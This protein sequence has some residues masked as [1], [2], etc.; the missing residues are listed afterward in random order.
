MLTQDEYAEIAEQFRNGCVFC[1]P[2]Q[3]L[4]VA[5]SERFAVC[6]DAAPLVPGHLILHST[7]HLSCAGEVPE[8]WYEELDEIRTAVRTELERHY[9]AVVSYEHGRAGHC[10]SDGPEHR[11]CHHFHLHF[12]PADLDVTVDLHRRFK[13]VP[14]A[15]YREIPR[16]YEDFGDYLFFETVSGEMS[17]FPVDTE[18]ERH[19]MRT[20]IS[21]A[22]KTPERADWRAYRNADLLIASMRQLAVHKLDARQ[23]PEAVRRMS[24]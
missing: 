5:R 21:R 16:L 12:V 11:L 18:I 8:T 17:Y 4:I 9:G 24:I 19:L 10:L 13:H 22:A 7:E 3:R 23:T 2:D 6:F 1:N 15:T 20:L 14:V